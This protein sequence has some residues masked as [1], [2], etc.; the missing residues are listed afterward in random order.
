[1]KVNKL[2]A[3]CVMAVTFFCCDTNDEQYETVQV[4]TPELMSKSDFRKQVEII[5]PKPS[6]NETGKI[7]AYNEY[8]FVTDVGKGVQVIDN[9][10]PKAPKAITF[11]KI[12]INEDISVKDNVLYADSATDLLT[13]DISN[14]NN[15]V[16]KQRLKDVFEVYNYEIPEDVQVVDYNDFNYQEDIIV[17]WTITTEQRKKYDNSTNDVFFDGAISNSAESTIGTGGSLARF[18]IVD[19]YL[20]AVGSYKMAIFN[21]KNLQSPVLENTQYAGWNIETLFQANGYLYLGSTNGM[22]IYSIENPSTPEFV[23]EFRHWQ[24]CDPVVVDGNYA[25]LTLRGGNACGQQE[26]VLEVIDIHE[27]TNPTLV[28]RYTLD[29]PYGLGIKDNMLFVCDGTSGL[30]LFDKTNPLNLTVKNV[31]N[32]LQAKDVIP[33]DNVL[34][35]IGGNTI[36]QYSYTDKDIEFISSFSLN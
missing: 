12:P 29:N 5:P 11:I 26:S 28:G 2:L 18:Q 14:I 4:A 3:L 10:D 35:L 17:G 33:L 24:G 23:S 21:I 16:L 22:Y 7:Y 27:K 32:N 8:I 34:L 36:Y 1:M 9:S 20:Y 31:F 13:F 30:K 6:L 19:N 15:I 25:Y